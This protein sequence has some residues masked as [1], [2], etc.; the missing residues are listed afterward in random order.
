MSNPLVHAERAAQK[1]GGTSDDYLS[2]HQFFDSAKAHLA[3]NRHRLILH[4]SFGIALAERVFGPAV[5]NS[6]GR[7]VFVWDIGLQHV[8]EDL[9]FVPTLAK[10]LDETPLRPWMAGARKVLQRQAPDSQTGPESRDSTAQPVT[11]LL[12][13][14]EFGTER[15]VYGG[16]DAALEGVRR[17]Y[18][19]CQ[20]GTSQDGIRRQIVLRIDPDPSSEQP[21]I[22]ESSCTGQETANEFSL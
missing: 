18:A 20:R 16:L 5:T 1:W 11:V 17:L 8:L 21:Q 6:K 15:F 9:G 12:I 3:D 4:N 7:R 14:V 10:C 22:N 19:D 2:V 13:S